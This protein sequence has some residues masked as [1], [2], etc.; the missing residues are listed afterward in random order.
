MG[1]NIQWLE[2]L[3]DITD[4]GEFGKFAHISDTEGNKIGLHTNNKFS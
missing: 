1:N 4:I 2:V 3:I